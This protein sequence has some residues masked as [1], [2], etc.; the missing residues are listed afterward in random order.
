MAGV[1][2]MCIFAGAWWWAGVALSGQPTALGLV[3][4][5][6]SLVVIGVVRLFMRSGVAP[7]AAE[8]KR[9]GRVLG[10]AVAFEAIA[11]V[12]AIN[13]LRALHQEDLTLPAIAV[14]VGL[15]F[16]PLASGLRLRRYYISAAALVLLGG[17]SVFVDAAVRPLVVGAGSAAVLWLTCLS[18]LRPAAQSVHA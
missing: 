18:R 4:P 2:L 1:V 11:I 10:W 13:V 3:G 5:V 7:D 8:R 12:V 9:A 16:L 14:I 6:I 15:H 17:G